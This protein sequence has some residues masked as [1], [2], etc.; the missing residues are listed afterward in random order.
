MFLKCVQSRDFSELHISGI[1]F[2]S[3]DGREFTVMYC[4]AGPPN[5]FARVQHPPVHM[6]MGN[7]FGGHVFGN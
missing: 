6:A 2:L 3:T 4:T 5:E 7:N 1:R